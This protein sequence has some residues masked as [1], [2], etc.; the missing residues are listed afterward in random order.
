MKNEKAIQK[1][2]LTKFLNSH[3]AQ[4]KKVMN[5]KGIC[6]TVFHMAKGSYDAYEKVFNM[7]KMD[8]LELYSAVIKSQKEISNFMM[9][10]SYWDGF[11]AGLNNVIN[12]M[13]TI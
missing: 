7:R 1:I 9:F 4:E 8:F 12:Y 13:Q 3:M 5:Q 2:K 11:R 10:D 6:D